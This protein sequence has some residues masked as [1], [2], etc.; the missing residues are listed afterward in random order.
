MAALSA[1]NTTTAAQMLQRLTLP[2][3]FALASDG[4]EIAACAL[5]VLQ[6]AYLGI[7][8]VITHP[9]RR[10]RGFAR[11]IVTH[12]LNWAHARGATHAYLQVSADNHPALALYSQLGFVE[13]YQYWYRVRTLTR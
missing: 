2:A 13:H 11:G 9:S 7:F 3:C 4:G 8:D 1:S 12:L 6:G 5:G 10:R